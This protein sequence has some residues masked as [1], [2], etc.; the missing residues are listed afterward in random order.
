MLFQMKVS[1]DL[2]VKIAAVEESLAR[3]H[4]VLQDLKVKKHRFLSLSPVPVIHLG[5]SLLTGLIS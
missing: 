1:K 3:A 5:G 2:D 4:K